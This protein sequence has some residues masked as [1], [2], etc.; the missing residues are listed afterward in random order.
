MV[1]WLRASFI[2][3]PGALRSR[4]LLAR[5][6]ASRARGTQRH[7]LLCFWRDA[8]GPTAPRFSEVHR[9]R[10]R[11]SLPHVSALQLVVRLGILRSLQPAGRSRSRAKFRRAL[12][13]G[14]WRQTR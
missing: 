7:L 1:L 5:A 4:I 8:P 10:A 12:E 6:R 11:P 13:Q 2:G 14:A 3:V 9:T